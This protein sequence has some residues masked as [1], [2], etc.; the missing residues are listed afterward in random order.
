MVIGDQMWFSGVDSG[1][2][3]T[4][5]NASIVPEPTTVALL[6]LGSLTLLRKRRRLK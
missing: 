4:I 5:G 1:G 2:H 6:A 3:Y